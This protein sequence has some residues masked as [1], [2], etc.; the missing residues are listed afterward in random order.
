MSP[1]NSGKV[2]RDT[3]K[4]PCLVD[5]PSPDAYIPMWHVRL[6]GVVDEGHPDEA[7][8]YRAARYYNAI[9]RSGYREGVE[10]E[11]DEDLLGDAP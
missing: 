7:S 10:T 8:A 9:W 11:P 4:G 2:N 5:P 1:K 6:A 3:G